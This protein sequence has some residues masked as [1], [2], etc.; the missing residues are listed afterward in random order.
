MKFNFKKIYIPYFILGFFGFLMLFMGIANHYFFRSFVFDYGNYNFAFW[1]Y[2]HFR[3]SSMPTYPGNFLQDHYSFL[4]FYFVP[5]YWLL[6]WLTGSYTLI[7]IQNLLIIIAAWYSYKIILLKSRNTYLSIGVL[8]LYFFLLGRYSTFACDTNLAVMSACFIPIFIYYFELRKYVIASIIFILSLLSRENIPIWF[9]F[10]FIV[11]IINHRKDKKAVV[12]SV[13]GIV[14]SILYFLLLF[15]VLIPGI[16]NDEKQFTLFNYAALG[17]N[18]GDAFEYIIMN[19]WETV[20]LFFINHLDNP[21]YDGIKTEFYLVYMISGGFILLFRPKYIIWFIP[22]VAQKVLNDAPIRWGIL[23]YYSIEIVTL[24]PLSVFMTLASIRSVKLQKTLTITVCLASLITT[25]YKMDR[26]HRVVPDSF[27]P[28]KEK[29]YSSEF[30]QSDY[31]LKE[32]HKLLK[33]IPKT[34]KVSASEDFFPHLAQRFNIYFF[35]EVND[36]E[37]IVFS[38]F[39]DYFRKSHMENEKIRNSYLNSPDWEII[40]EEFPVFLLKKKQIP[41]TE[42]HYLERS[43]F[44]SDTLFCD[45]ENIDFVNQIVLF[46]SGSK[47]DVTKKLANE[48]VKSASHSLLL[49]GEQKYGDAIEFNDIDE[50]RYIISSVWAKGDTK[51]ANIAVNL[52]NGNQYVSTQVVE[53]N[54]DGWKKIQI[55]FWVPIKRQKKFYMHLYN[56]N[57]DSIFFDDFKIIHKKVVNQNRKQY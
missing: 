38:V 16:E 42:I 31:N 32:T 41:S 24:L 12:L 55:E 9:I 14:I 7:I 13:T 37:Y 47:A 1:D 25:I 4:L 29:V 5:I 56:G 54:E 36:A 20:K 30:Y 49:T 18:P 15:K 17:P 2:S 45:F 23:T 8:L 39:D 6:N 33:K 11:L 19:P 10:I 27:R 28:E 57:K 53:E 46:D 3:I 43:F 51:N 21:K 40:A 35:P 26:V 22:V 50:I 48:Q 34:A 44:D 52:G